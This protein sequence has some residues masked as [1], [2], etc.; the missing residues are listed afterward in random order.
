MAEPKVP[1][2]APLNIL[3]VNGRA[4]L[5][6]YMRLIFNEEGISY[7]SHAPE[8]YFRSDEQDELQQIYNEIL[9]EI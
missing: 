9:R 5:K 6:K 7:V 1:F 4:L 2:P 8:G 3:G